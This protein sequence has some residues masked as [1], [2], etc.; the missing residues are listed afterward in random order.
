MDF[1]HSVTLEVTSGD[2]RAEIS[3]QDVELN[4]RLS[5]DIFRL[6][7]P[8]HQAAVSQPGG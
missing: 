8:Q 1:A 6:R 2:T 5:P 7:A 4:P 3:L